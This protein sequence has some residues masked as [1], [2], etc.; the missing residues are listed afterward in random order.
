MPPPA[1]P[2]PLSLSY[3]ASEV[4][5]GRVW[6]VQ[7]LWKGLAEV[8]RDCVVGVI[9]G[10]EAW[11]H[12]VPG[13]PCVDCEGEPGLWCCKV[14]WYR[15]RCLDLSSSVW[16]PVVCEATGSSVCVCVSVSE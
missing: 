7:E 14:M 4:L 12:P 11:G 16:R 1:A 13:Y 3:A 15:P 9:L 5:G 6:E 2:G 10:C 8:S